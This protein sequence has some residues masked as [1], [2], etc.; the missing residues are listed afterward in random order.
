MRSNTLSND[1]ST[2]SSSTLR[3]AR[4]SDALMNNMFSDT[5]MCFRIHVGQ[6]VAQL[7]KTQYRVYE[8][9]ISMIY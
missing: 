1:F 5:Y 8:L 4:A 7:I 2:E 9:R 3:I 6:I